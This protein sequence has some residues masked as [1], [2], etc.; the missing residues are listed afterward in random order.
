MISDQP[1]WD[2]HPTLIP[3]GP[4]LDDWWSLACDLA[5]LARL[6]VTGWWHR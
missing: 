4:S 6:A 2:Y 1:M 5:A 3:A